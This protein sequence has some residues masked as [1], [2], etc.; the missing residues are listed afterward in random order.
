MDTHAEVHKKLNLL[1]YFLWEREKK[2]IKGKNTL[3]VPG[4]FK[5]KE[6]RVKNWLI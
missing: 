6:Q 3:L 5:G 4:D 2:N 1:N